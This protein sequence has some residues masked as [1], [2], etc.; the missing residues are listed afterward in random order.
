MDALGSDRTCPWN[1]PVWCV[2][3]WTFEQTCCGFLSGDVSSRMSSGRIGDDQ[4]QT[5]SSNPRPSVQN[6]TMHFSQL[7]TRLYTFVKIMFSPLFFLFYFNL[8]KCHFHAA[9][10]WAAISLIYFLTITSCS[11]STVVWRLHYCT[12]KWTMYDFQ[13]ISCFWAHC[14]LSP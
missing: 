11:K 1:F 7:Q 5:P 13:L 4:C 2:S 14:M 3:V 10:G 9:G 12:S 6:L 8:S